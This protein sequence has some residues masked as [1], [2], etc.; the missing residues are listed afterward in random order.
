MNI[1]MYPG[2]EGENGL[3]TYYIEVP[4][5]AAGA[6]GTPA[7]QRGLDLVTPVTHGAPGSGI[8]TFNLKEGVFAIID[9]SF[10][11]LTTAANAITAGVGSWV[12]VTGRTQNSITILVVVNAATA[13]ADPINGDIICC[14]I[15]VKNTNT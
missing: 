12:R 11:I 14:T 2:L 10:D 15:I 1:D 3:E 13:A 8:Y 7:R 9:W 6:P 4:I 5:G